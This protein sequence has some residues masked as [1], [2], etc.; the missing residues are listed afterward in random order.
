MYAPRRGRA[1]LFYSLHPSG[2][3]NLSSMHGGCRVDKGV[4]YTV[5]IWTFNQLRPGT[6]PPRQEA[7]AI[8]PAG[9]PPERRRRRRRRRVERDGGEL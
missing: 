1:L 2:E 4:K 3:P 9:R 5:N 7:P 8:T 6:A